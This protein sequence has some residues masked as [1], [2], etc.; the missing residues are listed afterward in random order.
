MAP[1]TV[2]RA[3]YKDFLQ[4]ALQR[5]FSSTATILLGLSYVQAVLLSGWSSYF[6]SWFPI[7]PAGFRTIFLFTCG[8]SILVLRIAQYHVGV[9][10]SNSTFHAFTKFFFSIHTLEAFLFYSFS[11]ALFSH[12]YLWALPESANLG[13]V[14]YYSGGERA[15]V[16]ERTLCFFCY[17]AISAVVQAIFHFYHDNDKLII[18]VSRSE[19]GEVK[20]SGDASLNKVLGEVPAILIQSSVRC[21][22]VAPVA[23]VVHMMFLRSFIWGW[24]LFFL[25]P[26]YN[27]PRTNMLPPTQPWD[28]PL[29]FRCAVAGFLINVVWKTA[30]HAFSTFMVKPPLKNGK[31]LTSESKDP[32][33]SLL[34]GLKSKKDPVRCFA[35]W[36]LA[37]I[38]RNDEGRR[39]AIFQ[40]IDRKDGSTWSQI[41]VHCLNVIKSIESRIDGYGKPASVPAAPVQPEE[42]RARSSAPLKE[43]PIFQSKP[44]NRTMRG[45]MEKA[46]TQVGRHPGTSPVSQLSPI[47]KKTL[48]GARD[49]VLSK[50]QQEALSSPQLKSQ[51]QTW[52]LKIINNEYVGCVFRQEFRNRLTAVVLGTPYSELSQYVNAV[53][54][55]SLLAVHSLTEDT[56]GKVHKDIP[57]IIRTF[58]TV[59]NK[60]EVFK[61]NFPVHWTDV[62]QN[63]AAPEVDALIAALK[64]GLG[65]VIAEFEPY[66]NDLRLTRTDMRLAK[67]AAAQQVPSR[68]D[69]PRLPEMQQTR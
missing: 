15:R 26:F 59:I 7:G 41:Y 64:T 60:I 58:T 19:G 43:D 16:N 61:T 25:R 13:W 38:A 62:E 21:L 14:T 22:S 35:L 34:N 66:S 40:D 68:E 44:A 45:E 56:F 8:L 28:L 12:V 3:P 36:E 20:V 33:G 10:A 5:R 17:M 30:N 47:A 51:F 6:W 53:D 48:R 23:G 42:A 29:L 63:R 65:Q 49:K 24:A 54:V 11:S 57:T 2:R 46:L 9:R 52:A 18:D 69:K 32:N 55:L 4:P 50:E 39:K 37:Y 27:I 31:P 67:E 1:A